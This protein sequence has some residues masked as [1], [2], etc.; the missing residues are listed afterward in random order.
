MQVF[1]AV[2]SVVK[3]IHISVNTLEVNCVGQFVLCFS[4]SGSFSS[5]FL[6]KERGIDA[7]H[8]GINGLVF[9][10]FWNQFFE[11]SLR[12]EFVLFNFFLNNLAFL[13][14]TF[15]FVGFLFKICSIIGEL[16][17]SVGIV[18]V[19]IA[20]KNLLHDTFLA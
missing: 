18:S 20:F 6:L 19:N 1:R 13:E 4:V 14:L 8:R 17:T 16:K 15:I 3:L 9:I 11:P 12:L 10:D 5:T 2:I 7:Y